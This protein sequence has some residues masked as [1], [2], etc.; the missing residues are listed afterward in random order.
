M[1]IEVKLF[2]M[3]RQRVGSAVARIE[4]PAG[5]TVRDLRAA[6]ASQHPS[7]A[8]SVGQFRFAIDNEYAGE[9]AVIPDSAEVACIP[10]VSGG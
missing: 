9:E 2:A 5:A 7:L 3:A 10:P 1:E 6:F 4:L 8:G